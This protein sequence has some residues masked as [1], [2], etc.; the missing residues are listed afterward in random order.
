PGAYGVSGRYILERTEAFTSTSNG[1]SY[2]H[3]AD[4]CWESRTYNPIGNSDGPE[5]PYEWLYD[6]S[7]DMYVPTNGS[8]SGGDTEEER[9]F[10]LIGN[11]PYWVD[12]DTGGELD[13]SMPDNYEWDI[14]ANQATLGQIQGVV[15]RGLFVES[16]RLAGM[17]LGQEFWSSGYVWDATIGAVVD[18]GSSGDV[19]WNLDWYD[20]MPDWTWNST[21]SQW[22][23]PTTYVVQG[24]PN[25]CRY[26]WGWFPNEAGTPVAGYDDLNNFM[27]FVFD[28]DA[29]V[30]EDVDGD[31]EFDVGDDYVLF[32]VVD[33]GL[34]NKYNNWG[35]GTGDVS[36]PFGGQYFDGDTIFLYDG[37][38][39]TTFFDAEA[40]IF[41]GN[42]ISTTTGYGSAATL[43]AM[44]D[45][46]D[47]DALDIGILPEPSTIFLMIGSASGLAV[48]AGFM[49][50]KM[51]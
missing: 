5:S 41:F 13:Y 39:V 7:G 18:P 11:H 4:V 32:S 50:R 10:K 19:L 43:W 38:S 23:L 17:M 6:A 27:K 21:T 24:Y 12:D 35:T 33:D 30:V 1:M 49:R 29:V 45:I 36:T 3:H 16:W 46:Y 2:A 48:V 42:A 22:E 14:W 9:A 15:N 28:I 40:G 47:L 34:Y 26:I 25:P 37:T 31:G 44:F 8:G 20:K 51:R